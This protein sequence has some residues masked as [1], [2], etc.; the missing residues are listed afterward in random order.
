MRSIFK[1]QTPSVNSRV[2]AQNNSQDRS[3]RDEPLFV[4]IVVK[5]T[6]SLFFVCTENAGQLVNEWVKL[7]KLSAPDMDLIGR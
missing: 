7:I 5:A 3:A 1:F 6:R 2:A 4:T